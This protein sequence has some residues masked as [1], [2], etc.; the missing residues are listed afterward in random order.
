MR[1]QKLPENIH[2]KT[3][4]FPSENE[5]VARSKSDGIEAV[6]AACRY[7]EKPTPVK[8][9]LAYRPIGVPEDTREFMVIETRALERAVFPAKA[10]WLDEVQFGAGV[11]A[12]PDHIPRIGRNFRLKQDDG[13]HGKA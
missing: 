13:D 4:R 10:E 11:R 7:G 3:A 1:F 6:I 5:N 2:R 12:Q 9:C 8:R